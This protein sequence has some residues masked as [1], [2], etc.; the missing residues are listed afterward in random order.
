MSEEKIRYR[1]GF[2]IEERWALSILLT[3]GIITVP[4]LCIMGF[5]EVTKDV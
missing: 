3:I 5:E 1:I 2:S 4:Y